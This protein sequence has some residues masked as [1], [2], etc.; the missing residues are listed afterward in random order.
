MPRLALTDLQRGI[1][2]LP[3]DAAQP[4]VP[5]AVAP[6]DVFNAQPYGVA[7]L[8]DGRLV[9]ADRAGHRIIAVAEDGTGFASFGAQGSGD[10]QF[11]APCGV[12]V[13]PDG[14]IYVAD[15]GNYR[16]VAL[17][18]MAGDGWQSYGSKAGPTLDDFGPGRFARLTAIAADASGVVAADAGAAR[19]VRLSSLDDA[20]WEVSPPGSLRNPVSVALLP[21]GRIAVADLAA[22]AIALFATPSAG[23]LETITDPLL[24]GPIALAALDDDHL[25]VC[26][27]PSNA[28]I[29]LT[30]AAGAWSAALD[31]PLDG[32]GLRRPTSLCLLP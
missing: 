23:V 22:P 2:L 25:S 11:L 7:R 15:S 32:L 26:C 5:I 27:V 28:L 31:R 18:S 17:Q 21:D 29:T 24:P 6:P 3:A 20:G 8:P 12:A 30:R 10:G 9:T 4:P 13:G 1:V 16:I 19:I 14:R